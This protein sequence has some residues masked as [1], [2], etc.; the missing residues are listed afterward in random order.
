M[1]FACILVGFAPAPKA[2]QVEDGFYEILDK[3]EG[4]KL[5]CN[6]GRSVLLGKQLSAEFGKPTISSRNNENTDF[7]VSLSHAAKLWDGP[8]PL[9]HVLVVDN[10]ALRGSGNSIP[11]KDDTRDLYYHLRDEEAARK[12]EKRL[13]C[14]IA[15]RKDP[16]HRLTV[17]WA[18]DK[19]SYEVGEAAIIL[20]FEL[21][22]TGKEAVAFTAGGSQRGPRDN[23]FRF[24]AQSGSGMGKGIPDTGDP[25][26][27]GGK[28]GSHSLKPGETFTAKVELNNWFKFEEPGRLPGYWES[29]ELHLVDQSRDWVGRGVWDD[30]VCG[31]CNLKVEKKK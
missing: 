13:K 28:M 5:L 26:N 23:Q 27:F 6:D 7:W 14:D 24:I 19:E 31:E 8:S 11:H 12:V 18:P 2:P 1:L 10:V 29:R 3:G 17:K 4:T 9:E 22:N 16:G 15:Y 25:N 30:L 21:K 20:K